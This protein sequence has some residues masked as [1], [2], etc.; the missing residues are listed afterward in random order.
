MHLWSNHSAGV[1]QAFDFEI[2]IGCDAAVVRIV[3]TPFARLETRE[4][5]AH[6]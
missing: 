6:V 5:G 2:G 3:V 4:T 1:D